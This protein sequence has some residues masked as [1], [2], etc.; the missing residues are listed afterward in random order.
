[1]TTALAIKRGFAHLTGRINQEFKVRTFEAIPAARFNELVLF[2]HKIQVSSN[3]RIETP[4]Y[5]S[6]DVDPDMISDV[7]WEAKRIVTGNPNDLTVGHFQMIAE[8][9]RFCGGLFDRTRDKLE[10]VA[11]DSQLSRTE[12]CRQMLKAEAAQTQH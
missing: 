11:P 4:F 5:L 7:L 2:V 9:G 1:A 10:Q 8:M 6:P 3:F 12:Q